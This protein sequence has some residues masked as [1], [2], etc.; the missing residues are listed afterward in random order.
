ML[1]GYRLARVLG[2]GGMGVVYEA[3]ALAAEDLRVAVKVLRRDPVDGD[4]EVKRFEREIGITCRF[5][6]PGLIRVL[7]FGAEDGCPYLVMELLAGCTLRSMC[8][9]QPMALEDFRRLFPPIVEAVAHA[10]SLGVV[11]RD[12]KSSN[13]IVTDDGRPVVLDFGVSKGGTQTRITA[14]G[15]V[16]GTPQYMAPEQADG[17][18]PTE[19]SDQ[20]SLGVVAFEMLAG[21]LP[22]EGEL[23]PMLALKLYSDAPPMQTMRSDTPAPLGAVVDRMLRRE[24]EDRFESL[25]AVSEALGAWTR[26]E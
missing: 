6:H 20:Y 8:H 17:D 10:H 11:H 14:S 3:E 4:L 7:D 16:V 9:K 13:V 18:T 21:R 5:A 19:R 26:S 22:F 2:S 25:Q 24:P 12:L 23:M 15:A 1:G